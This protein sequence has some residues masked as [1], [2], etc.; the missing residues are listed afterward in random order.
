M[1][2][3]RLYLKCAKCDCEISIAKLYGHDFTWGALRTHKE[4]N[5]WIGRHSHDGV[6][7]VRLA[8]ESDELLEIIEPDKTKP[9]DRQA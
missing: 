3:N 4:M 9:F 7:R 2:Q 6:L 8:G 1:A 5:D